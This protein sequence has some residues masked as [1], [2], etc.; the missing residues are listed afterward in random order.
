MRGKKLKNERFENNCY[1]NPAGRPGFED[2]PDLK[3]WAGKTGNETA[4]G[5]FT[6]IYADP[7][8][9]NVRAAL[10]ASPFLLD[11]KNLDGFMPDHDSPLVDAGLDLAITRGFQ[12][13]SLDIAGNRIP[14]GKAF[15]IG[16]V[17]RV[18]SGDR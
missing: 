2:C 5:R 8:L 4:Q 9:K 14:R 1:W 16:A 3:S 6:G 17:E 7:R 12:V 13:L 18:V 10:P 15:D 11:G